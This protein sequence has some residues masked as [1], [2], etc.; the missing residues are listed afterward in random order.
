MEIATSV[1][2]CLLF[3][4][5]MTIYY[6]APLQDYKLQISLALTNTILDRGPLKSYKACIPTLQIFLLS[7]DQTPQKPDVKTNLV[8][9]LFSFLRSEVK[10]TKIF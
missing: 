10:S 8:C 3:L 7:E 9:R 4:F 1:N 2:K 5:H 6:N